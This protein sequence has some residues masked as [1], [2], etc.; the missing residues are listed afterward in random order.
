MVAGAGKLA[1]GILIKTGE[2]HAMTPGLRASAFLALWR[3]IPNGLLH[4]AAILAVARTAEVPNS[5]PASVHSWN[6]AGLLL[7][8]VTMHLS[9]SLR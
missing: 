5:G 3:L 8:S 9:T 6:A 2:L 4:R 1:P 7:R